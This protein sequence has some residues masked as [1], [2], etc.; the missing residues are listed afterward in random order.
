MNDTRYSLGALTVTPFFL[1]E[2]IIYIPH[3][4]CNMER[5]T[6]EWIEYIEE[7]IELSDSG[8]DHE[9]L[10]GLYYDFYLHI[11]WVVER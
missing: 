5:T 3:V 4:P 2:Y 9:P 10:N 1:S 8:N 6:E 7:Q 11:K